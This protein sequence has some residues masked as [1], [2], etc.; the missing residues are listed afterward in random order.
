MKVKS[1]IR[2]KREL[3]QMLDQLT[4]PKFRAA[5]LRKAAKVT[6]EPVKNSL[7]TASPSELKDGVVIRTTVNTSKDIKTSKVKENQRSELFSTVTYDNAH[8][9]LAMILEYGRSK[10]LAK[11]SDG[12]VFHSWGKRTKFVERDIG[13]TAAQNFVSET[14]TA[15]EHKMKTDFENNLLASIQYQAKR[16][17][18]RNAKQKSK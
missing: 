13:T 17:E 14:A 2:G 7:I 3:D 1:N 8:Y 5:A 4:D 15:V 16:L 10:R 18:K 6:M 9:G 12:K 11:T